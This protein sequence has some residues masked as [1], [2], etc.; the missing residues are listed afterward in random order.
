VAEDLSGNLRI[1]D[2]Y[3][4]RIRRV[5]AET[6]IITSVAGNGTAGFSGDGG[7]ALGASLNYPFAILLD[8]SGYP[9]ISDSENG[10]IRKAYTANVFTSPPQMVRPGWNLVSVP[11][12]PGDPDPLTVFA[13]INVPGSSFQFWNNDEPSGYIGY[14][15]DWNGPIVR[16]IPYWFLHTGSPTTLSYIGLPPEGDFVLRFGAHSWGSFWIMF[17]TP[18]PQDVPCAEVRF[19]SGP[20]TSL[21]WEQAVQ[22]G[23][24]EA[25]AQGWNAATQS[26]L[27]AG[28]AGIVEESVLRPWCGYWL[29]VKRPEA[30]SIVFPKP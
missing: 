27:S 24:V 23:I 25:A 11:A 14:G 4:H 13:G 17:G 21:P 18:F 20:E 2:Q 5:S 30:L 19:S 28:V 15:T 12:D 10:R 1:A 6:G 29:L 26:F 22:A 3:N 16:G 8:P 9:Y 7:P